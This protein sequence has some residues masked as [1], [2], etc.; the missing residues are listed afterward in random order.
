MRQ[1][2][3]DIMDQQRLALV[4]C[5]TE[6]DIVRKCI[7]CSYFHQAARLKVGRGRASIRTIIVS[8]SLVYSVCLQGIGEYVN[9]R[10]GMPC[11]LHPTSSLFG[12]GLT[13]D[14]VV[15][16]ELVMTSKVSQGS[17]NLYINSRLHYKLATVKD[18]MAD[19]RGC[20]KSQWVLSGHSRDLHTYRP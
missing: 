16:H 1:Q 20:I 10:T 13:P 11:H 18:E 19:C 6:W 5:G 9:C 7:C 17:F 12:M 3:K 15:Y 2:L 14:Y 8:I 4:S